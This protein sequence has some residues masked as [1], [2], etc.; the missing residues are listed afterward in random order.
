M[1]ASLLRSEENQKRTLSQS[2]ASVSLHASTGTTNGERREKQSKLV[3]AWNTSKQRTSRKTSAPSS[4]SKVQAKKQ[5]RKHHVHISV[6]L[7]GS[8]RSGARDSSRT[9]N[10]VPSLWSTHTPAGNGNGKA[11]QQTRV[12]L[13][14]R[15]RIYALEGRARR[16]QSRLQH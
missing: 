13:S 15:R 16:K 12:P 2:L 7:W 9:K 3:N 14:R 5:L 10:M 11:F 8:S 4:A 1:C 6:Y